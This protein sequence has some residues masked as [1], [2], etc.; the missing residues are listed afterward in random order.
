[1]LSVNK[2]DLKGMLYATNKK[3]GD[4]KAELATSE[5]EVRAFCQKRDR[6]KI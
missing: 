4:L 6:A 1:M 3:I 2:D 5:L